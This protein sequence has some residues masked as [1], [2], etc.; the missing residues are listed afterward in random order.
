MK[1]GMSLSAAFCIVFAVHAQTTFQ[2][3]I[4]RDT[5]TLAGIDVCECPDGSLVFG[6]ITGQI[7]KLSPSGDLIWAIQ[8]ST[9]F[10]ARLA[11]GPDNSI[12][13][14]SVSN[15][16]ISNSHKVVVKLTPDG[17]IIWDKILNISG[18]PVLENISA[19]SDG[20]CT[21]TSGGSAV[22]PG[23]PYFKLSA[24]G[25]VV[26]GKSLDF[27]I[28]T[29][30]RAIVPLAASG[31]IVGGSF[32]GPAGMLVRAGADGAPLWAKSCSGFTVSDVSEFPNGHLLVAG[33]S[34]N[35]SEII[36]A[37]LT[38]QGEVLWA[39]ATRNEGELANGSVSATPDG[40]LLL[41][42]GLGGQLMGFVKMDGNG[43]VEWTRGYPAGNFQLGKPTATQDGGYLFLVPSYTIDS[44]GLVGLIKTDAE[45]LLPNCE[46]VDICVDIRD[47]STTTTNIT[48]T[49][50]A[51]SYDTTYQSSV[52]PI[53]VL[54]EDYCVPPVYPI[55][56][57][58]L[59]DSICA[60]SSVSPT[61]LAQAGAGAWQWTF[62]GGSPGISTLQSPGDVLF[63][64]P[65]QFE[66]E[67]VIRFGGCL[68][69]FALQ[70]NVLPAP[71]PLLGP[72]TLLCEA[73]TYLLNGASPGAVSYLWDD[74][75]TSPLRQVVENGVYSLT[76][77]NGY[78]ETT[79]DVSVRF[80]N[81]TYPGAVL[82]I[83]PDTTLCERLPHTLQ[84]VLPGIGLLVWDDGSNEPLRIIEKPG[85]F[86]ATFFLENCPLF[87][88]VQIAY[89]DCRGKVYLPNAF[90]PNGDGIN[91]AWLPFG[92]DVVFKN[93]KIFDR[94]GSLLLDSSSPQV[95]WDGTAKGRPANPGLYVFVVEYEHSRTGNLEV[96]SGE[97]I[98]MR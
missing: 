65:G 63:P 8:M 82:D 98:L 14:T 50:Q 44:A 46:A 91:D 38:A 29:R 30:A 7:V 84:A 57:F 3:S 36:F 56:V 79:T 1:K 51:L 96:L 22:Q 62:E 77:S 9:S 94:W 5:A 60:G 72:D 89:A 39:K 74:G 6:G 55:P 2:K 76:V 87:D 78:C 53:N 64:V 52:V 27:G 25:N 71:Q 10:S 90:S 35:L 19:T 20:G 16:P 4:S 47:F 83:G 43:S 31:Y 58:Q 48:W 54:V 45:G 15:G 32:N 80:F 75:S 12:F 24:A 18:N 33:P 66:V 88:E 69:S 81:K 13:Y 11:C 68:D 42:T 17:G 92:Q 40:G 49:E 37:R 97:V 23:F 34:S 67:Q 70:I 95:G 93:L 73:A 61:G 86:S 28:L 21:L 26:F 41:R 85:T 59:P